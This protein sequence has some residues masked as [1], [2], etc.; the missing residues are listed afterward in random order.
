MKPVVFA[1]IEPG[2]VAAFVGPAFV[3]A[4]HPLAA[5]EGCANGVRL[6]GR[7]VGDLFYSGPGA[8]PDVTAAT[9]LDDVVETMT[10]G[11]P[12]RAEAP[13]FAPP[14]RPPETPWLVRVAFPGDVPDEAWLAELFGAHRVWIR[15]AD[16]EACG[17][18]WR[19]ITGGRR[20]PGS[21]RRSWR[22]APRRARVPAPSA[23]WGPDV[24]DAP[25]TP[26]PLVVVKIGGSVLTDVDSYSRVA[27]AIARR[28][29]EEPARL[30]VVVSA[31][32]GATDG[33][34]ATA[35][36]LAPE[37]DPAALDLLW[38]TGELRSVAL[39]TLALQSRGVAAAGLSV[40]ETGLTAE[41]R[42]GATAAAVQLNPL[43]LRAAFA[44]QLVVIVPGFLATAGAGRVVSLGRGGSDLTAVVVAAALGAVRCELV[45][46]V[47]GYFTADPHR[48]SSAAPVPSLTFARAL[49]MADGGCVLVQRDALVAAAREGLP[50]V[51]RGL[52]GGTGQSVVCT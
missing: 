40:H 7:Y 38:S 10:A 35:R 20:G 9:I 51:V 31:E 52:D 42:G 48:D 8:G 14:C 21:R 25:R 32:Q 30:L 6:E 50:I 15:H 44:G 12:V 26:A 1:A 16:G 46:D 39:L 29:A 45:K 24:R 22:S 23:H 43:R 47:S 19:A 2:G 4:R 37:P 27:D 33:L 11:S 13:A 34:L 17:G 28:I 49:E 41:A 18:V 5:L 3:D 36:A